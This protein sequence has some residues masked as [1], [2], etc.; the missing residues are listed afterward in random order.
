MLPPSY[1]DVFL[2]SS[3]VLLQHC[4]R[5]ISSRW[6]KMTSTVAR[7][8]AKW[9]VIDEIFVCSQFIAVDIS[10]V[11]SFFFCKM[12]V[13]DFGSHQHFLNGSFAVHC[14]TTGHNTW[15]DDRYLPSSLHSSFFG[16][17]VIQPFVHVSSQKFGHFSIPSLTD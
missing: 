11:E 1:M 17:V 5:L 14:H 10:V 6:M 7:S 9:P 2:L 12:E 13:H 15:T 16:L 4:S 3:H 8:W